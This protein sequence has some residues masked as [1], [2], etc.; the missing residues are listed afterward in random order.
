MRGISIE[1]VDTGPGI[2]EHL[3]ENIFKSAFTT[4]DIKKGTGLGLKICQF[5]I[6][7]FQGFIEYHS[8]PSGSKFWIWI[9]EEI[10]DRID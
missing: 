8:L 6:N 2:P 10:S 4:K 5:I 1:I 3:R 9:P 7:S